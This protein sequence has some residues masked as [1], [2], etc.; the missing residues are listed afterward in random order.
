MIGEKN[1]MTKFELPGVP[2]GGI[3]TVGQI[4]GTNTLILHAGQNGMLIA[5]E[6]LTT[7]LPA[8]PWS[9]IETNSLD[10]SANLMSSEC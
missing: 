4:R 1:K 7:L 6:L 9:M 3:R 2:A 5:L 8:R 10:S